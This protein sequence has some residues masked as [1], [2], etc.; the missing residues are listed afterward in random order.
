MEKAFYYRE[1]Y[2]LL[3][4]EYMDVDSLKDAVKEKKLTLTVRQLIENHRINSR[5]EKGICIAPYFYNEYGFPEQTL[6]LEDYT[7]IYP[8][9]VT[10]LT[11]EEYNTRLRETV[12]TYCPGCFRYK[13]INKWDQSLNGHFEEIALN[14][15]CFYRQNSKPAPRV[16][17]E[18][19]W[20][21]GGLSMHFDP[22][23]KSAEDNMNFIKNILHIKYTK[24]QM[25]TENENHVFHAEY[26]PNFFVEQLTE[27]L[28]AY[29][30]KHL[31]FTKFRIAVPEKN[32]D[33]KKQVEAVLLPENRESY[34]KECKKYGVSVAFLKFDAVSND[35]M[36]QSLS[37]MFYL[38]NAKIV[39]EETGILCLLL[40]NQCEFIKGLHYRSPFM[41]DCN[42]VA[43]IH[44]QYGIN[45]YEV[46]F[47]MKELN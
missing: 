8:V 46:S 43:E 42:T 38:D 21:Y 40:M 35:K 1:N 13:P 9:D 30:E 12:L 45:R 18:L 15:V 7:D 2:Y 32:I 31:V 29:I 26:K 22:A 47:D 37:E 44:D 4:D 24:A 39:Y 10:L 34:Q 23:G 27:A 6:I 20:G 5:I 11:Q 41:A 19:L 25:I 16:F 33:I 36:K 14:S 3:P 28:A 17:K